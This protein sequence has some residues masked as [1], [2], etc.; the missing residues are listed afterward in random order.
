MLDSSLPSM[1]L[2]SQARG[3]STPGQEHTLLDNTDT[4]RY[5]LFQ[6]E[7]SRGVLSDHEQ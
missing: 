6:H 3:P 4:S 7:E 5:T 1:G 2:P